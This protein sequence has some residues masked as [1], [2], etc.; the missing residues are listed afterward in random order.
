MLFNNFIFFISLHLFYL[1]FSYIE[2]LSSS[3][4]QVSV[5]VPADAVGRRHA[6]DEAGVPQVSVGDGPLPG[7]AP[8][9]PQSQAPRR[10]GR[11][12]EGGRTAGGKHTF[13]GGGEGDSFCTD[14]KKGCQLVN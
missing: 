10:P 13:R 6:E 11:L 14:F 3:P 5:L 4:S 7:A 2:S 9:R 1:F 8:R 12:E